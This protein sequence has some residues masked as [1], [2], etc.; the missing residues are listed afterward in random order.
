MAAS[1]ARLGPERKRTATAI[2][3]AQGARPRQLLAVLERGGVEVYV[4]VA[5]TPGKRRRADQYR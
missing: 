5:G 3:G 1:A 2:L 4:V